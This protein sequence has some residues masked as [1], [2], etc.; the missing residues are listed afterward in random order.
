MSRVILKTLIFLTFIF[1]AGSLHA[2]AF[3]RDIFK[4]RQ[5]DENVWQER[6]AYL[7]RVSRLGL[8]AYIS[9]WHVRNK[10][11]QGPFPRRGEMPVVA[12][13][14][15][16]ANAWMRAIGEKSIGL[17][18]HGLP[19]NNPKTSYLRLGNKMYYYDQIQKGDP[20]VSAKEALFDTYYE[21][22]TEATF[23]VSK[24]ELRVL[25]K[26]FEDRAEGIVALKNVRRG[27]KEG[28]VIWPK[29]HPRKATLTEESCAGAC[30]SVFSE[31]WLEHYPKAAEIRAVRDRL[32]IIPSH[33]AK[34]FIWKHAR[35]PRLASLTLLAVR[36]SKEDLK[37]GIQ[38]NL[39]WGSLRGMPAYAI[40]PDLIDSRNSKT[41]W[42]RRLSLKEWLETVTN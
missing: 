3:C 9:Q 20:P 37:L 2:S 31:K 8:D 23:L 4:E 15:Q 30:S 33:V 13:R 40:V 42:T 35:N 29:F 28:E 38:E 34:H 12:V 26:F 5:R 17:G 22:Y 7:K 16:K 27:P 21:G 36:E 24:K 25:Q 39:E 6:L 18:M 14:S 11:Y 1:A 19:E 32:G 10:K 41:L